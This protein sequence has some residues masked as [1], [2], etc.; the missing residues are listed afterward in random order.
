MGVQ[1]G[2]AGRGQAP[3]PTMYGLCR[4]IRH[5]VA[6][7][8]LVPARCP[9]LPLATSLRPRPVVQPLLCL[10]EVHRRAMLF[11]EGPN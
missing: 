10:L 6:G 9:A 5:I 2:G 4:L 7:R 11:K 8:G 1:G 3:A